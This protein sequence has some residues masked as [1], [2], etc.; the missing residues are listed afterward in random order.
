M[1]PDQAKAFEFIRRK[2][3]I[4]KAAVVVQRPNMHQDQGLLDELDRLSDAL[5]DINIGIDRF[6]EKFNN[7]H[8][9]TG[10][11]AIDAIPG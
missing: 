5:G 6:M 8:H 1:T 11:P 10:R 9:E 4:A 7:H 2:V 3:S